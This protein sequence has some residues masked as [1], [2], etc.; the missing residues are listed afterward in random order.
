MAFTTESLS[1]LST[2]LALAKNTPSG[3]MANSGV[4]GYIGGGEAFGPIT[5]STVE[6]YAF[7]GDSRSTVS[8][9]LSG[10]RK[11]LG[12]M[13]NS[14]TAGYFGG[15]ASSNPGLG[16]GE[17]S[18][19]DKFAFSNDSRSALTTGL[20]AAVQYISTFSN[21]GTAGYFLHGASSG[22]GTADKFAF[23]NDSRTT[24]STGIAGS[25]A[26]AVTGMSNSGTAGY[27]CGNSSTTLNKMIFSNDTF[28][29]I[30]GGLT[31][32]R[33]APGATSKSGTAGY[34]SGGINSGAL[35]SIEKLVFPNDTKASVSATLSV[36]R[37][38]PAGFANSG[39]L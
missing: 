34:I 17:Q 15:G 4:A 9:G 18:N 2:S 3:A 20:S 35:N 5:S 25:P 22:L 29:S 11:Y 6:K 28:S 23:S 39:T 33:F 21:S 16:G 12:A 24:L 14:G 10:P 26:Q 32:A 38:R 30:A 13:A 8:G 27:I 37:S 36:S 31:S 7:A 1:A 19:V